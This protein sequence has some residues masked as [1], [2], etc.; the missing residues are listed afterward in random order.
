M[1]K[2]KLPSFMTDM[3]IYK[4]TL[5][6]IAKINFIE[7]EHSTT[8]HA[9]SNSQNGFSGVVN[10]LGVQGGSGGHAKKFSFAETSPKAANGLN[11]Q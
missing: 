8:H 2:I 9:H 3:K 5:D 6:I 1:D 4:K 10:G 7:E 11:N